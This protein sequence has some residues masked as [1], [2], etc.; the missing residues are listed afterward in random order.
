MVRRLKERYEL[1]LLLFPV[2]AVVCQLEAAFHTASPLL[3][4]L[5]Y[6][7]TTDRIVELFLGTV[8]QTRPWKAQLS[9]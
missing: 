1:S 6:A 3:G 9:V 8:A 5:Y 4:A 2:G 7:L